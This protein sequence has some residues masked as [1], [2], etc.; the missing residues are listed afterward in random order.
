MS[1][2]LG[3]SLLGGGSHGGD[4]SPGNAAVAA[5]RGR[6]SSN[7]YQ[8]RGLPRVMASNPA[9]KANCTRSRHLT[10]LFD[11]RVSFPSLTAQIASGRVIGI[12]ASISRLPRPVRRWVGALQTPED[13][14]HEH[15]IGRTT[16]GIVADGQVQRS[17]GGRARPAQI[18]AS[19]SPSP[20]GTAASDGR[21]PPVVPVTTAGSDVCR[22]A[23]PLCRCS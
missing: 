23:I 11:W 4:Y 14:T 1:W 20:L 8:V 18:L 21:A 12:R 17:P 10:P 6:R 7:G 3:R 5:D 22:D 19:A 2:F 9:A 15:A 16:L 13:E